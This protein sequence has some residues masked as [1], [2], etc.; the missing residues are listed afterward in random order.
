MCE[1][2]GVLESRKRENFSEGRIKLWGLSKVCGFLNASNGSI[3]LI[4]RM[5][6]ATTISSAKATDSHVKI[7]FSQPKAAVSLLGRK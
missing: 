1:F 6:Y 7:S 5:I 2:D 4:R 3:F